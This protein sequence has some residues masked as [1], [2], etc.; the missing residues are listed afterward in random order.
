MARIALA[1]TDRINI[2]EHFGKAA[3]FY[4]YDM[5]TE[6]F[7]QETSD[8]CYTFIGSR[9][10]VAACQHKRSHS[11]S[12]FDTVAELLSDCDAVLVNQI[13]QGAAAYLISKG[14]RIFEVSGSID[15]VL[16]NMIKEKLL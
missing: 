4:V 12:D 9:D 3:F 13:G 6:D 2:N 14:L 11:K 7:K 1:S 8:A 5:E 15:E 16:R 10:A